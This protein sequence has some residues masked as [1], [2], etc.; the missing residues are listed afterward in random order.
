MKKI[1]LLFAMLLAV[2]GVQAKTDKLYASAGTVASNA[3]W[4]PET[5][6]FGWSATNSN[7]MVIF[8]FAAGELSKYKKLVLDITDITDNSSNKGSKGGYRIFIGNGT[9]NYN[10]D[11]NIETTGNAVE[12]TI[13]GFSGLTS[14]EIASATWIKISGPNGA[15]STY[16]NK[17]TCILNLANCYLETEEY[18]VMTISTTLNE[19]ATVTSPFQWYTSSDGSNKTEISSGTLTKQFNTLGKKEIISKETSNLGYGNGFIDITG[20]DNI[21]VNIDT[22]SGSYDNQVR[23]LCVNTTDSK[24]TDNF[25]ISLDADNQTTASLSGVTHRWIA[26]IWT[27]ASSSNSQKVTSFV[28]SK[29]FAVASTSDFNIAA[30][31]SSTI[32]YDREFTEGKKA[33]VCLPFSLN[34]S[35]MDTYGTFY[36]LQSASSEALVF[37]KASNSV[38]AY[39]PYIF[40]PKS[41]GKLFENLTAKA[42]VASSEFSEKGTVSKS[43]GT[44]KFKGTQAHVDDVATANS[45]YDVYG[46]SSTDGS[47][48]KAGAGVSIDAFRAYIIGPAS[49]TPSRSLNA[50]FD[51]DETTGIQNIEVNQDNTVSDGAVYNIMGQRVSQNHKGLVI[52]NGRKMFVR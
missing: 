17:A 43:E 9:N 31:T 46:W 1:I 3:S 51:D 21:T 4:T 48:K 2:A 15:S 24:K 11:V 23:L 12:F 52:K 34:K 50:V 13:S 25:N 39:T 18:E 26:G 8:S 49:V 33:T 42:I 44:W 28:F 10:D 22:Y 37:K 45:G 30:S 29:E 19:D 20:Y 16:W 36:Y 41:S 47:F 32:N 5:N 7:Q 38:S 6:T 14:D 40:V 35:E 27:K